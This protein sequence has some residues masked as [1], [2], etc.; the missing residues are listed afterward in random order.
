MIRVWVLSNASTCRNY[1]FSL[2]REHMLSHKSSGDTVFIFG[3]LRD[4][5]EII[6]AQKFSAKD[7]LFAMTYSR[8]ERV[9]RGGHYSKIPHHFASRRQTC[10]SNCSMNIVDKHWSD[11][12]AHLASSGPNFVGRNESTGI[13]LRRSQVTSPMDVKASRCISNARKHL[14]LRIL[15]SLF[16]ASINFVRRAS[17]YKTI[18]K[19]L[20]NKC[21]G[22]EIVGCNSNLC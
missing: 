5:D 10:H 21:T 4:L 17:N 20:Q 12:D 15:R 18:P 19:S 13:Y 22:V 9:W 6:S 7:K 1:Q 14:T 11:N 3:Q 16:D 2:L 8:A